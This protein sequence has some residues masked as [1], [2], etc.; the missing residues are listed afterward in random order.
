MLIRSQNNS[1]WIPKQA[2]QEAASDYQVCCM[3]LALFVRAPMIQT[4]LFLTRRD[5][6]LMLLARCLS[7]PS[8]E[9]K[10]GPTGLYIDSQ[11]WNSCA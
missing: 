5:F 2:G 6:F 1:K 3:N 7:A 9:V 11:T 10:P 4:G 8:S